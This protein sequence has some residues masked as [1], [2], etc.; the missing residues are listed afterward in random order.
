MQSCLS[1]GALRTT[2]GISFSPRPVQTLNASP[3]SKKADCLRGKS[4]PRAGL[5]QPRLRQ[6]GHQQSCHQPRRP[7]EW[8]IAPETIC[9]DPPQRTALNKRAA[10]FCRQRWPA[11]RQLRRRSGIQGLLPPALA[12]FFFS[13]VSL[14]LSPAPCPIQW[15]SRQNASGCQAKADHARSGIPVR[16]HAYVQ[17]FLAGVDRSQ[18]Q[19]PMQ[20]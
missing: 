3:A 8:H 5:L 20:W 1:T 11:A 4:I 2:R 6:S 15:H 16:R 14:R 18:M 13:V 7:R 19:P 10:G 17:G 9:Q 12:L